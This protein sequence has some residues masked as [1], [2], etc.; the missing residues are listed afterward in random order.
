MLKRTIL[1]VALT[2]LLCPIVLAGS[3]PTPRNVIL[4]LGDGMGISTIT[5]ARIHAGQLAGGSGEEHVLSFETFPSVALIKTFNLDRQVP[6]SAGTMSA[7][8][9]GNISRFGMLSVKPEVLRGD[10]AGALENPAPTL[11]EK[12]ERH[13]FRTGVV[14]TTAITHA[15]PG[16]TYAHSA[17]RG[18]EADASM[19]EAARAQG[20]R[21]IARQLLEL[22]VGDGIEVML[23][24]GRNSFF[25]AGTPDPEYANEQGWRIDG[26]NL[27]KEWLNKDET[28]RYV[29]NRAQFSALDPKQPGAVLGLFEPSHMQYE[30]DRRALGMQEPSLAD[31]TAFAIR[32][33]DN[34]E[35]GYFLMVEGGRIDHAHHG[36][37]AARA[38]SDTLA[39]DSAVARAL[40][41]TDPAHTLIL[42]TADH[43][44]TLVLNGYPPRGNPILGTMT[45]DMDESAPEIFHRPY[46][47]LGYMNGPGFVTPLPDL[48]DVDTTDIDYRQFA[49]FPAPS[50]THG[51]EDVAAY[52]RGRGAERLRGVMEQRRLHDILAAALLGEEQQAED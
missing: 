20:C 32:R 1:A 4:F 40:E 8:M 24:G 6:D 35:K 44:H 19:P 2:S 16:A 12:A 26:R 13:G 36:N 42:V 15:T 29:W 7:I 10:C 52:A 51:G 17:D 14:T 11:L 39:L 33:L 46:T 45:S 49:G 9:T 41:L 48:T 21:D 23:G 27:V 28:R 43:S 47:T 22:D 34:E 50:E 37:N 25:P 3:S 31:M 30:L 38:L 18:W 5:A